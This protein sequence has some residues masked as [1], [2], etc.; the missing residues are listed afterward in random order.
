[1]SDSVSAVLQWATQWAPL[2][3][4]V[5]SWVKL[6]ALDWV[7][8]WAVRWGLVW[9]VRLVN[10]KVRT[11]D[12]LQWAWSLRDRWSSGRGI[13]TISGRHVSKIVQTR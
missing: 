7:D 8:A 13:G 1:M 9:V 10:L 6:S 3:M 2:L 12:S 5:G 4:L 11:V